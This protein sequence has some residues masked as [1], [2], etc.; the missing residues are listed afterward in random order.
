MTIQRVDGV[1]LS[2]EDARTLVEALDVFRNVLRRQ[3]SRPTER[4]ESLH[5]RLISAVHVRKTDADVSDSSSSGESGQSSDHD[6][7]DT[8]TAAALLGCS[9]ANARDLARRGVVPAIHVGGRW[10][11]RRGG[12]VDRVAARQSERSELEPA[13]RFD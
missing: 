13:Y 3:G 9:Q 5:N 7:V 6:L 11:L 12:V 2:Q 4:L 8:A 1:V 10:L